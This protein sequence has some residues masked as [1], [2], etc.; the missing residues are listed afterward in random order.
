MSITAE[1]T[2]AQT[3]TCEVTVDRAY[4]A[5]G[6]TD[7]A[8]LDNLAYADSGHTGFAAALGA[9]DNY[10][11]DAEKTKLTGIESGAE[12][13]NIS[14]V[15]ATD[16][17]DGGQ[18]SLHV[19]TESFGIALS[20]FE[21]DIAAGENVAYFDMPYAFRITDVYGTMK[22]A[23]TVSTAIFDIKEAG[24]SILGNKIEIE[25]G[26]TSSKTATTQ[27]SITDSDIA[28]NAR[29]TY[30]IDQIGSGVAGQEAIV[31]I[32]GYKL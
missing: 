30:D 1:I 17:T 8:E 23:P 15:N 5:A 16:L 21:T 20:N 18:T 31:F 14:D 24:V 25:A 7:H 11:T 19:H 6:T 12:V 32:I 28:A 2:I 22:V 13:N 10:M 27:P 9:D 26:E 29:L 3:I 4:N